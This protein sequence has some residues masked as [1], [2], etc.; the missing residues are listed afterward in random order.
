MIVG[1]G[2]DVDRIEACH[3]VSKNNK[4][5]IVKCTRRKDCQKV[6]NKKKGI[7]EPELWFTWARKNIYRQ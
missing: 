5:V 6:W 3:R 2:I 4:S 7:K 1:C